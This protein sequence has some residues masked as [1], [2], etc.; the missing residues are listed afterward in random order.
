MRYDQLCQR[1]FGKEDQRQKSRPKFSEFVLKSLLNPLASL[2]EDGLR[3]TSER[4]QFPSTDFPYK[5]DSKGKLVFYNDM[6][7]PDTHGIS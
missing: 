6:D 3:E 7:Y 1:L 4:V 5:Q 2:D